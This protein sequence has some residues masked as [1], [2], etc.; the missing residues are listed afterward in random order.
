LNCLWPFAA[1]PLVLLQ[2]SMSQKN[3]LSEPLTMLRRRFLSFAP[4][5]AAVVAAPSVVCSAYAQEGVN[6]KT[7]N[8]GS[9]GA[10]SGPLGGYGANLKIGVNAALREINAKGG[11]HG[12][13]LQF[14]M[15]DD[16]YVPA[17][18]ADNAKQLVAGESVLALLSCIG[19]ANNAA[20][21]PT[22]EEMGIPYVAPLTGASSL[23]KA[24]FKSVFHVR[25]SYTDETMR[26]VQ[27][28]TDMGM[29]NLAIVYLDNAYGKEI[30]ADTQRA[31]AAAKAK[32][33]LEVA[34]ATDGKNLAEVVAKI[35]AAK[36][37]AVFMATA[38]AVSAS[39][40]Q[41]IRQA[42]PIMPI[43][44]LSATYTSDGL[45]ALGKA[46]QGIA[47][48]MVIPDA[49]QTRLKIVRDYQAA[50]LA[51]GHQDFSAGSLEAYINTQVLAHGIER[52]GRDVNRAK[53]RTALTGVRNL[54]LGGF[55]VDYA[56]APYV[57]SKFVGLGIL[58]ASGHLIS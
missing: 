52:A 2:T 18:S 19:T 17:R 16:A 49:N 33:A 15:L 41:A 4:K 26:V 35:S 10:L 37:A 38:G 7:I 8:I 43:A 42:S 30:L 5:F 39:L 13:Q 57:G 27:K 47:L 58:S 20:I 22:I 36:P 14:S 28:L 40:T 21:M 24:N 29:G 23:R 12:R 3:K 55:H 25:A 34:V 45:K 31:L 51:A 9:T 11:I 50:M 44:G 6:A 46:S 53:L 56:A 1:F 48:A 32:P 54:D